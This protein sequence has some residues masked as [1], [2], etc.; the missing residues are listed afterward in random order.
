MRRGVKKN[1]G[2][3]SWGGGGT[4]CI[5]TFPLGPQ[6]GKVAVLVIILPNTS[7]ACILS[8]DARFYRHQ[9]RDGLPCELPPPQIG[10][11]RK[12]FLNSIINGF[13]AN[14]FLYQ[15]SRRITK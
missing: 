1:L 10:K 13:Q 6:P 4:E 9:E 15:I 11:I 7:N 5:P 12:V 14:F 2:S 3:L 8:G